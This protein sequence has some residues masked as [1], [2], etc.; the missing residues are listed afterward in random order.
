VNQ[1]VQ[2]HDAAAVSGYPAVHHLT[3]P[4]RT[5]AAAAGDASALSLWAGEGW[6]GAQERPVADILTELRGR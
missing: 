3:R 2:D 4:L 5:A 6:R 1:F